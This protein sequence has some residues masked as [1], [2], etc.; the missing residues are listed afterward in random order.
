MNPWYNYIIICNL[1]INNIK[2][3]LNILDINLFTSTSNK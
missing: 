2:F 1:I 3:N